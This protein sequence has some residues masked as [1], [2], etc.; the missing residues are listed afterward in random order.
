VTI[1]N[2][3][4]TNGRSTNGASPHRADDETAPAAKVRRRTA[5][6]PRKLMLPVLLALGVIF[7][8]QY[9]EQSTAAG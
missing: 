6:R 9:F 7:I 5:V 2:T 3:W 4:S 1:E 8:L